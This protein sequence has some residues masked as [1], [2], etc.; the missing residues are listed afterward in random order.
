MPKNY[1][2]WVYEP[3]KPDEKPVQVWQLFLAA[4][5]A[6]I[7]FWTAGNLSTSAIADM[8]AAKVA[9]ELAAGR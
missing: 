7:V 6:V 4:A 5:C 9:E 8:A 1:G 2:P 3:R